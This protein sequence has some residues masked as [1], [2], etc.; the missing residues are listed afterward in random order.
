MKDYPIT[1]AEELVKYA[2]SQRVS[3]DEYMTTSLITQFCLLCLL[4][5]SHEDI[6]SSITNQVAEYRRCVT[7]QLL[8]LKSA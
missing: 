2:S 8:E 6:K 1:T 7:N 5:C 3:I 4:K